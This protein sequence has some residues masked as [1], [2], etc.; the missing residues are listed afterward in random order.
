MATGNA[1]AAETVAVVF[2][3]DRQGAALERRER[4]LKLAG[5]T[6]RV[7]AERRPS[8]TYYKLYVPDDDALAAH[9]ALQMGGCGRAT[10]LK[11]GGS[12]VTGTL[13]EIASTLWDELLLL[14]G[15]VTDLVRSSAPR[16]LGGPTGSPSA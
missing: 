13:R 14:V 1:A 10:R 7:Q 8:G 12:T 11:D 16:L 6:Y 2:I 15:R 5:I 9:L 3:C 4:C